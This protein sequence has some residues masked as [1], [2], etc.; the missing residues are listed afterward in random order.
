[1][2]SAE[3]LTFGIALVSRHNAG[4]WDRVQAFL[5]LTL[6]S[7]Q[8]QTD[9]DFRSVI[10]GHERPCLDDDARISFLAVDWSVEDA[11]AHNADSGRTH[12]AISEHVLQSGG[13]LLMYLDADDRVDV[14]PVEVARR[15]IPSGCVGG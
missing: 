12:H 15:M 6:A 9:Q 1:M 7:L 4:D 2:P 10:A 13:G 3:P 14:C 5:G 8:A 11:D